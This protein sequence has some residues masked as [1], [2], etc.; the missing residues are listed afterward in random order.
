MEVGLLPGRNK[1]TTYL[2][3]DANLRVHGVQDLTQQEILTFLRKFMEVGD[4]ELLEQRIP[5]G[6]CTGVTILR[7]QGKAV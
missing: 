7:H 4:A 6:Q 5:T 2:H 3:G 1:I